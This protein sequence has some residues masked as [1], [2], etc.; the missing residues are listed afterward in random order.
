ML[1]RSRTAFATLRTHCTSRMSGGLS[2]SAAASQGMPPS[3][4]PRPAEPRREVPASGTVQSNSNPGSDRRKRSPSPAHVPVTA[5][6]DED[7]YILTLLT[8]A[9][10]HKRMTAIRDQYFPKRINK[11]EAHLTLFHALPAS[12]MDS[13]LIPVI[14]SVASSTS[15][16]KVHAVRPFRLKR[17]VAIS[18]AKNTGSAQ[19]Q[20]VHNAL[21]RPW[22]DAEFL[23]EQDR[24]GCRVHYT[25]MNKVEDEAVIQKALGDLGND[26]R[27][28]WGTAEG[29]GLWKY[30]RGFWRWEQRFDFKP[31]E[32]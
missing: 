15:A 3:E 21:Q 29:L 25:V 28:D 26:F 23:S 11:L 7:V 27:G 31:S 22:L 4:P 5:T 2:Y 19:A 12:R 10:H 13:D 9:A 30:D 32:A 8:D 6:S 20:E 18:V 16:F 24:G 14:K 1:P 17:G